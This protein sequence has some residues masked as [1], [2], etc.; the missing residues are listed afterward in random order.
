MVVSWGN[1]M[2]MNSTTDNK[3]KYDSEFRYLQV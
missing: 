1:M 3:G 2:V